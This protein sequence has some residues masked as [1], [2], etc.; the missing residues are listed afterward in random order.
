MTVP[1]IFALGDRAFEIAVVEWMIFD[2]DGK[3]LYARHKG[4]GFRHRPGL[5]DAAELKAKIVVQ[6]ACRM[7]LDYKTRIVRTFDGCLAA[8]L[9]C[10]CKITL[11]AVGR[12]LCLGHFL[13]PPSRMQR[14]G[15]AD[16]STLGNDI[17]A[18]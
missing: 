3:T 11:R 13:S 5:E 15:E 8:R 12:E 7:L 16:G 9:F 14:D 1:P 2:L 6:A 18:L 4:R 10:F 17:R